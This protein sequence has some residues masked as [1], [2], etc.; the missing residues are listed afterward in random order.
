[1]NFTLRVPVVGYKPFQTG[2]ANPPRTIPDEKHHRLS[3]CL[4]LRGMSGYRMDIGYPQQPSKVDG[5]LTF[6][7][8]VVLSFKYKHLTGWWFQ[9]L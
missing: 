3:D 8:E 6:E 4:H 7:L 1:M 9:S 5:N 2:Q